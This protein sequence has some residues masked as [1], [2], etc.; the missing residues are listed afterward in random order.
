[1]ARCFKPARIVVALLAVAVA[2]AYWLAS[3]TPQWW[4]RA[5]GYGPADDQRAGQLETHFTAALHQVRPSDEAWAIEIE[6]EDLNRWLA[7]RSV[8]W[9]AFD[10][11]LAPLEE[12][13]RWRI[14]ARAGRLVVASEQDGW[15]KWIM[16][17]S[18]EPSISQE[19]LELGLTNASIGSLRVPAALGAGALQSLQ[20]DLRRLL[21]LKLVDGRTVE[22]V[23]I[24]IL[25]GRIVLQMRTRGP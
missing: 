18:L 12:L 25:P 4:K 10:P 13:S 20:P 6:A 17:A 11:E 15:G 9:A 8:R 2:L 22:L 23:D 3:S 7:C 5:S 21:Q 1:M 16:G 14:D 24:E 19:G